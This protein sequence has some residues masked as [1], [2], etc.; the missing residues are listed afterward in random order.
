[1]LSKEARTRL[2]TGGLLF[3]A[4]LGYEVVLTRELNDR[5]SRFEDELVGYLQDESNLQEA[6]V[7]IAKSNHAMI[8]DLRNTA[9]LLHFPIYLILAVVGTNNIFYRRTSGEGNAERVV[10]SPEE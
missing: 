4:M 7:V 10:G 3:L 2:A 1:M 9:V 6:T 8:S 5:L